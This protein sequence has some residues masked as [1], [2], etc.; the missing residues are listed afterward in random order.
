V[1]PLVVAVEEEV[2]VAGKLP[3]TFLRAEGLALLV[4]ATAVYS[5]QDFSWL[6]FVVLLLTP[7]LFMVGYL[8]D[9]KL[10]AIIY[11]IGHSTVL[12][13]LLAIS[14][15]LMSNAPD[16]ILQ[17]S[18]IWFAHIGLDRMLGYGL[19]HTDNFKHTHLGRIN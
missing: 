16:V 12:P 9:T 5:L 11:N 15:L 19:K 3:I 18:L 6:M 17:L 8:H 2:A 14:Y 4:A 13:L 1:A 7:D 10:G